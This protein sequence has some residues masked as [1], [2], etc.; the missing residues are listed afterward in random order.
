MRTLAISAAAA[1]IVCA[2]PSIAQ[3]ATARTTADLN[4]R[5]GPSTEFPVVDVIPERAR[6]TVHG[7]VRAYAWCDVTWR[8]ARGWVSASYLNAYYSER[9]VPLIGYGSRIDLPIVTFSFDSYWDNHYRQRPWYNRRAYWH[10]YW[11]RHRD[12][13]R[14]DWQRNRRGDRIE[15]RRDRREER[16][17]RREDRRENRIE[18]RQER[19]EDRAEQRGQRREAAAE[20]RRDRR[21][22]QR[23]E[24]RRNREARQ[25]RRE[26]RR[27]VIERRRDRSQRRNREVRQERRQE[28]RA[29]R[30]PG[31]D[32]Q[33]VERRQSRQIGRGHFQPSQGNASRRGSQ[34]GAADAGGGRE[35]GDRR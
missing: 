6:L 29:Q 9:Y 8:D 33:R 12:D 21:A 14:A 22:D 18:R 1:V 11:R 28:R 17:E 15:R 3:A 16:A 23:R 24:R 19:R 13:F 34:R 26:E 32:R 27:A 2:A 30:A 10:S 4:M 31:S 5:A 20:R 35:R 7:C 25:E